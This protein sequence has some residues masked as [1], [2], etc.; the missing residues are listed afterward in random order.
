MRSPTWLVVAL[1]IGFPPGCA[2]AADL[3]PADSVLALMADPAK[4]NELR[5][6]LQHATIAE[7]CDRVGESFRSLAPGPAAPPDQEFAWP[8]FLN[9]LAATMRDSP[10]ALSDPS[11]ALSSLAARL[12]QNPR[13]VG[14]LALLVGCLRQIAPKEAPPSVRDAL[15]LIPMTF[16]EQGHSREE[17]FRMQS[18]EEA[19]SLLPRGGQVEIDADW[20]RAMETLFRDERRDPEVRGNALGILERQGAPDLVGELRSILEAPESPGDSPLRSRAVRAIGKLE[21]A[22]SLPLLH[23]IAR[24]TSQEAT[25]TAVGSTAA[26]IG[27]P[28]A[29]D[30][31]LDANDRFG[32]NLFGMYISRADTLILDALES[33]D[34]NQCALALR[35]LDYVRPAQHAN[36]P[37]HPRRDFRPLLLSFAI[38]EAHRP[39]RSQILRALAKRVSR[40]EAAILLEQI[41]RDPDIAAEWDLLRHVRDR[42]P[43]P[44]QRGEVA[45]P[46]RALRGNHEG[47]EY[48]DPGYKK[49]GFFGEWPLLEEFGHT[50]IYA[51]LSPGPNGTSIPKI[52]EVGTFFGDHVVQS[53]EWDPM[54]C[55]EPD[56]WGAFTLD[57]ADL[58]FEDRIAIVQTSRDLLEETISYP[59]DLPPDVSDALNAVPGG[60][61]RVEPWEIERLRCDGLIEY[62]YELNGF[63]V[64]GS[65]GADCDIS[66]YEWIDVHNDL[67]VP[68]AGNPNTELAPV[69]QCGRAG[70]VSTHM[71]SPASVSLPSYDVAYSVQPLAPELYRVTLTIT[72]TDESGIH[73]I[74]YSANYGFTWTKSPLQSQHPLADSYSFTD[75]VDLADSQLLLF[76]AMDNGG[77]VPEFVDLVYI[78]VHR[79]NP[80]AAVASPSIHHGRFQWHVESESE[81]DHY[82]VERNAGESAW[83]PVAADS[84]GPGVHDIALCAPDGAVHRLV[85]V[86]TSGRRIVHGLA[87]PAESA[88]HR[89][90]GVG[91]SAREILQR[92]NGLQAARRTSPSPATPPHRAPSEPE[93]RETETVPCDLLILTVDE[94]MPVV[95]QHLEPYWEARSHSVDVL[96]VG[97]KLE[98]DVDYRRQL[99]RSLIVLYS[100]SRTTKNFL[101]IGDAND[102]QE[103]DGPKT[104]QYWVGSWEAIRQDLLAAGYPAGGQPQL[105]ILPTYAV[106]DTAPRGSNMAYV[107]PYFLSD[108]P[109]V[110]GLDAVITRWPASSEE[111]VL[112]LAVK[113]Q[114]YDAHPSIPGISSAICYVGDLDFDDPGDGQLAWQFGQHAKQALSARLNVHEFDRSSWSIPYWLIGEAASLWNSVNDLRIVA[115]I[116]SLSARYRPAD[117]L[118]KEEMSYPFDVAA[119][120]TASHLPLVLGSSCG[121]ADFARTERLD[122]QP[123]GPAP[124]CEDFL[125]TPDMGALA[126]IGP[127]CGTWQSGNEAIALTLIEELYAQ[128]ERAI[129]LSWLETLR[130]VALEYPPTH[131]VH[132]TAASYVY[133][134]DPFSQFE[135]PGPVGARLPTASEELF[136]LGPCS[137]NPFESEIRISFALPSPAPVEITIHDISGRKVRTL[138]TGTLPAG[139]HETKWTGEDDRAER[140]AP[141]IY[142][143]RA[144]CGGRELTKKIVKW[145]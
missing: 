94:L 51:G 30:L 85:E 127:S 6:W 80:A 122:S 50:G 107:A 99:L 112:A 16:R 75:D 47:R 84:C 121:S 109:Y 68:H 103:F 21:G 60:G 72:A 38:D 19:L 54:E 63:P 28:G 105:N 10:H 114:D 108:Q 82:E 79:D 37:Y 130:R 5:S 104:S 4:S 41:P 48:G 40:E 78:D 97:P 128:P 145:K 115:V 56:C 118:N 66:R 11:A 133:L 14:A 124:I 33:R 53:N 29:L 13:D 3:T 24:E 88:P 100:M 12:Q 77:N 20:A 98:M 90:A 67:Y 49:L 96:S 39:L 34:L 35:G 132:R 1:A 140:V 45:P 81:T 91:E 116:G 76:Y 59:L 135:P 43:V 141:G 8:R 73:F 87:A 26:A 101:L 44:T 2:F 93:P 102:W 69:V 55:P 89:A 83:T 25:Y 70:G 129:A 58:Q 71:R 27:G 18:M 64:W 144:C 15:R 57:N 31:L 52:I 137:P 110:V 136:A 74:S 126:W 61:P 42:V 138:V 134:G 17:L 36:A 123:I 92:R 46:E 65:Y 7:L 131:P 117:I 9:L 95:Q 86:E 23:T 139:A 32:G 113:I 119:L 120:L 106:A 143:T 62:C 142:F 125:F 111:E 22:A